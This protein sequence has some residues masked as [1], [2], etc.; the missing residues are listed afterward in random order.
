[1][2]VP[3]IGRSCRDRPGMIGLRKCFRSRVAK[4]HWLAREASF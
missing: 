1:M 4:G 2:R 3:S